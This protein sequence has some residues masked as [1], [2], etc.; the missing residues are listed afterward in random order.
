MQSYLLRRKLE[1][2]R[3]W[4]CNR[5]C[6]LS[7]LLQIV[8]CENDII[9]KARY[10]FASFSF[11]PRILMY[12]LRSGGSGDHLIFYLFIKIKCLWICR[13]VVEYYVSIQYAVN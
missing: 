7:Q 6:F 3:F 2:K 12:S 1:N 8:K 5:N 4:E 13:V 10:Y 9:I 11:I